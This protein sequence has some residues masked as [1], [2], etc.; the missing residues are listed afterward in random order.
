MY[1]VFDESPISAWAELGPAQPQ[2]VLAYDC[3]EVKY[4]VPWWTLIIYL[5]WPLHSAMFPVRS[6]L[7]FRNLENMKTNGQEHNFHLNPT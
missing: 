6:F 4:S 5:T 3:E 7:F 2:L 1:I